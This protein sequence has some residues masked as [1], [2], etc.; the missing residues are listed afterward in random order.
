MVAGPNFDDIKQELIRRI[1]S[2]VRELAPGGNVNGAYYMPRNPTRNDRKAGSFWIR[3]RGTGIGAWRDESSGEQGDVISF[4]NY[5]LAHR[6]MKDTRQWCLQWIGWSHGRAPAMSPERKA[7]LKAADDRHKAFQADRVANETEAK[8]RQAMAWWLK[9]D[10]KII[11]TPVDAYL[12]SRGINVADLKQSPGAIRYLRKHDHFAVDGLVT[13]WPVM[14]TAMVDPSGRVR[15]VHRTYLNRDGTGKAPVTP[16]KKIWPRFQGCM[17]RL[18]KG[19]GNLT[20]EKA[21]TDHRAPLLV[22]EGIEDGLTFALAK[23]DLRIWAAATLGNLAHVPPLAC[24][25]RLLIAADNDDQSPQAQQLFEKCLVQLRSNFSDV[26]VIRAF[27][28]KDA[29]ELLNR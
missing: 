24:V 22:T 27:V 23:P 10:K 18:A 13:S 3:V 11:D 14:L 7:A 9:A 17:I 6:D 8:G 28:G 29:N 5:C 2:L 19:A 4:V 25:S 15:A 21:G 20:P 1:D 16:N 12:R 26:R